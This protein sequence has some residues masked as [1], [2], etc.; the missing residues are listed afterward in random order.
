MPLPNIN[1]HSELKPGRFTGAFLRTDVVGSTPKAKRLTDP[2]YKEQLQRHNEIVDEA[3]RTEPS[4]RK[5]KDEGDAYFILF[6]TAGQAVRAALRIQHAISQE[7]WRAEPL[8]VALSVYASEFELYEREAGK[9]DLVGDAINM[10]SRLHSKAGPNQLLLNRAAYD[11][12][13]AVLGDRMSFSRAGREDCTLLKIAWINHGTYSFKGDLDPATGEQQEQEVCEA[14]VEGIAPL[15]APVA[16]EKLCSKVLPQPANVSPEIRALFLAHA[17][18]CCSICH[19]ATEVSIYA[20]DPAR[21]NT[22]VSF[23]DTIALCA[24]CSQKLAT[25][26]LSPAHT[27]ATKELWVCAC[28]AGV[29]PKDLESELESAYSRALRLSLSLDL[30]EVREAILLCRKVLYHNPFHTNATFLWDRLRPIESALQRQQGDKELRFRSSLS[31]FISRSTTQRARPADLVIVTL[32][33]L[34]LFGPVAILFILSGSWFGSAIV[35]ALFV[36]LA[37]AGRRWL[38]LTCWLAMLP[39]DLVHECGHLLGIQVSGGIKNVLNRRMPFRRYFQ[40]IEMD[41]NGQRLQGGLREAVDRFRKY[42]ELPAWSVNWSR[43]E[44]EWSGEA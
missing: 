44:Y 33:V 29:A 28:R 13:R 42:G 43:M 39:A 27:R 31:A 34:C 15:K 7:L 2:V 14:G 1:P 18:H 32:I 41:I 23:S 6:G 37:V 17:N 35:V 21:Q 12:A 5:V 9:L 38:A 24:D 8:Q 4:A 30:Q 26:Q 16:T 40:Y 20:I 3:Y 25:A 22:A 11:S 19:T 10:A 36:T